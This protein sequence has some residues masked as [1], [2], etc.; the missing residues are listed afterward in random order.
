MKEEEYCNTCGNRMLPTS[1]L[2]SKKKFCSNC[3]T[4]NKIS[5]VEI[6]DMINEENTRKTWD[7]DK[8]DDL[9]DY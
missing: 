8:D 5:E 2:N 4:Q 6:F 7:F 9:E 1:S 3:I